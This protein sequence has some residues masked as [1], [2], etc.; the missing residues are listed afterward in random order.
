MTYPRFERGSHLIRSSKRNGY[1][2]PRSAVGQ[3][4][5][6]YKPELNQPLDNVC[7]NGKNA[8]QIGSGMTRPR[9]ERG[10]TICISLPAS[11][12]RMGAPNG[13]PAGT[14]K[15][16]HELE[17]TYPR[18]KRG[19][20]VWGGQ[21]LVLHKRIPHNDPPSNR[22]RFPPHSTTLPPL[23]FEGAPSAV[24]PPPYP[25]PQ[26]RT[27]PAL[28]QQKVDAENAMTH[29]RFERGPT[30]NLHSDPMIVDAPNAP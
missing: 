5:S 17:T 6:F 29:P 13:Q 24:G 22:T 20:A 10:P 18:I 23:M 4:P 11:I 26:L 2:C 15:L 7:A 19:P 12:M 1:G 8:A 28:G 25:S 21:K 14:A 30:C 9:F 27:E 16:L 3:L